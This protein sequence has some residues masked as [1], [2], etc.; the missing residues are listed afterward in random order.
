[1]DKD[2]IMRTHYPHSSNVAISK[3]LN[4]KVSTLYRV[5]SKMGLKK[6]P[7]YIK[8]STQLEWIM[9]KHENSKKCQFKKGHPTYNKGK[10][11]PAEVREKVKHTFFKKGN[12][13]AN[14]YKEAEAGV[15]SVRKDN[16]GRF[17]KF[18]KIAHGKWMLLHRYLWHEAYGDV[19][20]CHVVVFK[21][22]DSMN[23]TLDNLEC[24]TMAENMQRNTIHNLPE[25]I[26]ANIDLTRLLNRKIKRLTNNNQT[27]ES[28]SNPPT[29]TYGA[30]KKA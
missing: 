12:L 16:G 9:G 30:I 18:I 23:C 1:M 13:P 8:E 6:T 11:M 2:F 26:K 15:I 29:N 4:I 14:T 10:K 7:K 27:N 21:D 20:P 19:P 25:E 3:L 24:I 17:Y 22:G 28:K 5:A